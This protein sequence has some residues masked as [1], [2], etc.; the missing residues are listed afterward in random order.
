MGF[1][2]AGEVLPVDRPGATASAH[3]G[4]V[5]GGG[6]GD[7]GC[8]E[9]HQRQSGGVGGLGTAAR[10]APS[11]LVEVVEGES[12]VVA[13]DLQHRPARDTGEEF[14]GGADRFG[15]LPPNDQVG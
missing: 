1:V 13:E 4:A 8:A 7:A 6:L 5:Q 10:G 3:E 12:R 2:L 15:G 11:S 14:P 9:L